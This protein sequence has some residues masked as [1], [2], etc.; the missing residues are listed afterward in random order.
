MNFIDTNIFIYAHDESD[1]RKTRKCRELL[2]ELIS[3]KKACIST[4]VIQEF[5]NV[6][7]RKSLLPMKGSDV[8][9]IIRDEFSQLLVHQPD[10]AFYIRVLEIYERYSLS[11]YDAM[12]VQ[13][14]I[15]LKCSILFSEDLQAGAIYSKVKVVNPFIK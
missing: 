7:L 11:F 6:V 10:A 5:C 8:R 9:K 14:A 1:Q 3:E 15:D 2:I 4:Q 12:I 13:A